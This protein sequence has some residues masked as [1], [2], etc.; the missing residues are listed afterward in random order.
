MRE[1]I[2]YWDEKS[3]TWYSFPR[4]GDYYVFEWRARVMRLNNYVTN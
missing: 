3:G 2:W 1:D 4:S